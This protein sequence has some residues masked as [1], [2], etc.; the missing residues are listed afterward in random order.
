MKKTILSTITVISLLAFA[1]PAVAAT[2]NWNVTGV[3]NFDVISTVWPGTYSKTMTL[4]QDSS[5]NLTGTGSNIPAGQTWNINGNVS[6]DSINF[7]ATYDAPMA[8]YVA[9]FV[10]TISPSGTMNGTWSDVTYGD[11]G[12]WSTT[13]GVATAIVPPVVTICPTGTT[14]NPVA[15]ETVTV[16]SAIMTGSNSTS[17]TAGQSYILNVS[18]TWGNRG[19][20][21]VD[22]KYTTGNGWSTYFDA[23]AG[24]YPTSLLDLQ[25]NN[26]FIDWGPYSSSHNYEI[27]Y[28]PVANGPVNFRVFDGNVTTNTPDAGWYGDNVGNLLVNIYSCVPNMPPTTTPTN[29]DQCK[30][31]GWKT[32]NNPV[33][34]NQGQCVSYVQANEHAGKK[35]VE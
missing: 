13:N 23:P 28:T 10:G 16:N 25:L 29:K 11:S 21:L 27:T 34:K 24:G 4:S 17:L 1:L 6:G 9:T 31:D 19:W 26:E 33:F 22:A 20:E 3:W 14:K 15:L 8:G 18:G 5:G 2:P 7:S 30:K 35:I 12:P 32:F